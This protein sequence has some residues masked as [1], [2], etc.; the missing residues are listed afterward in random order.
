[1][2]RTQQDSPDGHAHFHM[3]GPGDM[4]TGARWANGGGSGGL[5]EK[6]EAEVNV[7]Q[8]DV[9]ELVSARSEGK[10]SADEEKWVAESIAH[11]LSTYTG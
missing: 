5:K 6:R 2:V 8:A 3:L 1:M 9:G 11:R 4:W 7:T 10:R